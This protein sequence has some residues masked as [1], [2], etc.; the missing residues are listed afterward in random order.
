[1]NLTKVN[2]AQPMV[3]KQNDSYAIREGSRHGKALITCGFLHAFC[4]E[5]S[6]PS[7]PNL[8]KDIRFVPPSISSRTTRRHHHFEWPSGNRCT[9]YQPCT[10]DCSN[11]HHKNIAKRA[12]PQ[13]RASQQRLNILRTTLRDSPRQCHL[14]V[15][16]L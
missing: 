15:I 7:Y 3:A 5:E 11:F 14:K 16:C 4:G 12:R 13:D 2:C 6:R 1:M 8:V 9:G 10:G